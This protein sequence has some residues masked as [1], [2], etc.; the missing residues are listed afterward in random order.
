[1]RIEQSKTLCKLHAQHN[2]SN[3]FHFR[4]RSLPFWWCWNNFQSW[5]TTEIWLNNLQFLQ[6]QSNNSA[7]R[8]WNAWMTQIHQ[9]FNFAF[10]FSNVKTDSYIY[11]IHN[12]FK[13][14]LAFVILFPQ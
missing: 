3:S 1:M 8:T 11:R 7:N 6:H 12:N 4:C 13:P 10:K 5:T 9:V 2:T 14:C